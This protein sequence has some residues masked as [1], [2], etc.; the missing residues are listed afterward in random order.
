MRKAFD[1]FKARFEDVTSRS[2]S[3]YST[4]SPPIG[5]SH[6]PHGFHVERDLYRYRKQGGVNLGELVICAFEQRV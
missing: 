1:K 4:T 2:P 5:T 3:R 6:L